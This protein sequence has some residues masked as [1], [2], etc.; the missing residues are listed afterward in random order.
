MQKRRLCIS[1]GSPPPGPSPSTLPSDPPEQPVPSATVIRAQAEPRPQLCWGCGHAGSQQALRAALDPLGAPGAP[2]SAPPSLLT[3]VWT[4]PT[5]G[6]PAGSDRR[7]G[8]PQRCP[9]SR[10]GTTPQGQVLTPGDP[11]FIQGGGGRCHWSA[12]PP[13]LGIGSFS[14]G[15]RSRAW[16]RIQRVW[17]RPYS[18]RPPHSASSR[19]RSSQKLGRSWARAAQQESMISCTSAGQAGGAGRR[20]PSASSSCRR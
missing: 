18:R 10:K 12:P 2:D 11:H 20:C 3:T 7:T 13:K 17:M 9:S 5:A 16:V 19:G 8:A 14:A 1:H 4:V 6:M 15:C